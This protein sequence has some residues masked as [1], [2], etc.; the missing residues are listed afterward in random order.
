MSGF[1]CQIYGEKEKPEQTDQEYDLTWK[2]VLDGSLRQ[3]GGSFYLFLPVQ[4]R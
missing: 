3:I 2:S 4:Q 1:E